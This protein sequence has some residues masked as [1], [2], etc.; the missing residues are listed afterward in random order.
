MTF[1]PVATLVTEGAL[2]QNLMLDDWIDFSYTG[3]STNTLKSENGQELTIHILTTN[4]TY[5]HTHTH[6][7]AK[8]NFNVMGAL[9]IP[10]LVFTHSF[11]RSLQEN[12]QTSIV[13]LR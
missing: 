6:L 4:T 11:K 10:V 3:S 1:A 13:E 12:R 8:N 5:T 7:P 9:A 2:L